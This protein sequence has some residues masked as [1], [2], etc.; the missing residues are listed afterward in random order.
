MDTTRQTCRYL[1]MARGS[2]H[3]QN[4]KTLSLCLLL[5]ALTTAVL[6]LAADTRHPAEEAGITS[7]D[8]EFETKVTFSNHSQKTIRVYWLN[9][10]GERVL[11]HTL[12]PGEEAEQLTFLMHPWLITDEEDN[13]GQLYFPDAQPRKID[14]EDPAED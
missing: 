3:P 13:A 2:L 6:P 10:E 7:G 1:D 12:N 9:F 5:A 4:M 8:S 14:I 11:Y